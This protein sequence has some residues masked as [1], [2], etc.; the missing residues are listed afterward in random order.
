[1]SF[2][3]N[4]HVSKDCFYILNLFRLKHDVCCCY[5]ILNAV[6]ISLYNCLV[7]I[8][9]LTFAFCFSAKETTSSTPELQNGLPESDMNFQ[10]IRDE[11]YK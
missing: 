4:P 7:I 6:T 1:M 8:I 3:K 5:L 10:P 2:R 11:L 9:I